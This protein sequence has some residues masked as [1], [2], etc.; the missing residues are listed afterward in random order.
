MCSSWDGAQRAV[1]AVRTKRRLVVLCRPEPYSTCDMLVLG[2]ESSCDETGVAIV[3]DGARIITNRVKSQV[4]LHERFGGVVP[5]IASRAHVEAITRLVAQALEDADRAHLE[6]PVD[7][8]AVAHR[9]GLIGSL[10]VGVTAA[11]SLALAWDVPFL[12][13]DHVHSHIYSAAM[14]E[15]AREASFEFPLVSLV[16]SGGHTTLYRTESWTSH[17][18]LGSTTDDA[19]GEA[20][21]KVAALLGLGYPGGPLISK[22]AVDGDSKAFRFP[23]TLLGGD[24]LDFSFSGIKTAVLYAAKGQ[25]APRAAP[26]KEGVAVADVAA[27]FEE[28]VVDVLIKKLRR[29]LR[30]ERCRQAVVA[31]GVAA[32][33]RLRDRLQELA[34][35]DG[36]EVFIPD[37][38]LCTDNAAMIA[39]AAYPSWNAGVRHD[40]SLDAHPM[41][42]SD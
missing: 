13:V 9:P 11:K 18:R 35:T 28:A 6:R 14:S 25:N 24:S 41:T 37:F 38:S 16:I 15:C 27:S 40:L 20:F 12:G 8:V 26:L 42:A 5:E 31:G 10:L 4:P 7:L 33:R 17:R 21:D 23:R 39:G 29:A 36:V 34:E 3:E 22:V 30:R 2:I 1:Q 32:N 19:V